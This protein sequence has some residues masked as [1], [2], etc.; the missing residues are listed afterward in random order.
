MT[1]CLSHAFKDIFGFS[2]L[3]QL[4]LLCLLLCRNITD[5][6]HHM[7]KLALTLQSTPAPGGYPVQTPIWPDDPMLSMKLSE[8]TLA[9]VNCLLNSGAIIGMDQGKKQLITHFSLRREAKKSLTDIVPNR[10]RWLIRYKIPIPHSNPRR[11]HCQSKVGLANLIGCFIFNHMATP[12]RKSQHGETLLTAYARFRHGLQQQKDSC[13]AF[14]RLS[15]NRMLCFLLP[16]R[17]R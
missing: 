2:S 8:I 5:H 13:R 4:D 11:F 15:E 7:Y 16:P 17:L 9:R 14:P 12:C 1:K 6:T 10:W 3:L